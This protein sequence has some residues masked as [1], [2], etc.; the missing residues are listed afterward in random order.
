MREFISIVKKLEPTIRQ[1]PSDNS[2]TTNSVSTFPVADNSRTKQG[3][4]YKQ[5]DHFKGWRPR[6]FVLQ[7][8]LLHY[9]IDN[10]DPTP[11]NT[12]DLTGAS[13]NILKP[14]TVDGVEYFPFAITHPRSSPY[15]LS[16]TNKLESDLWVAKL[17]EASNFISEQ[18]SHH[19]SPTPSISIPVV[20]NSTASPLKREISSDVV[21]YEN[22]ANPIETRMYTPLTFLSKIEK[23]VELLIKK[24]SPD[25]GLNWEPLLEKN[26]VTAFKIPGPIMTVKSEINLPFS[27]IDVFAMLTNTDRQKEL[28]PQRQIQEKLKKFSSHTWV[29]YIRFKA[30]WPT[31]ARDFINL[32]HW[33]ILNDNRVVLF[34]F[35]TD[36]FNNLR[37]PGADGTVRGDML[38]GG[39]ILTPTPQGTKLQYLVETDLKGSLP[40]SVVNFAANTQPLM[41]V[42]LK[43]KLDQDKEKGLITRPANT[44]P[45][46]QEILSTLPSNF[47][48]STLEEEETPAEPPSTSST[49]TSSANTTSS[50]IPSASA[51]V[52]STSTAS[53]SKTDKNHPPVHRRATM[54]KMASRVPKITTSSL[55]ILYLPGVL[56]FLIPN[57]SPVSPILRILAFFLGAIICFF[58][59]IQ[60]HLGIP[61]KK[62]NNP[63]I[64][65][66]YPHGFHTINFPV[67]L[68]QLL[69]Y[70]NKKRTDNELEITY[71]HLI[72]KA[73]SLTLLEMGQINGHVIMNKFYSNKNKSTVPATS[74][75]SHPPVDTSISITTADSRTVCYKIVDADAKPIEMIAEEIISATKEVHSSSS[76]SK[77]PPAIQKLENKLP[78]FLL[79]IV[80]SLL[81]ILTAHFGI[82][83]LGLSAFPYGVLSVVTSPSL[84][85][86]NDFQITT[87]PQTSSFPSIFS[88]FFSTFP[89][90]IVNIGGIRIL[91]R[92]DSNR[93]VTGTPV[94]NLTLTFDSRGVTLPEARKFCARM[95]EFLTNPSLLEKMDQKYHFDREEAAKRKAYF[96]K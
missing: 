27:V 92:L 2:S 54:L 94:L 23:N 51:S 10:V 76:D 43:Q 61:D 18:E 59:L 14:V 37:A 70:L 72:T 47:P 84:D 1:K 90:I 29:D 13:I 22:T 58:Y 44:P 45:T 4:L 82:S 69:L 53:S 31:S 26:G 88:Y 75:A 64:G 87:L 77:V 24:L 30:V 34:A 36:K 19:T 40:S 80:K 86:E 38:L 74:V 62:K 91:P 39:F 73:A 48:L 42:T 9:F 93:V 11:R 5:R 66:S 55:F 57:T 65:R 15:N 35:S 78:T 16:T 25:S 60:L 21:M 12:L 46:Y 33:R 3:T 96:G 7:D 50:P 68:G 95:Q 85:S 41:L 32:S 52:S 49:T 81:D 20:S 71:T 8:N 17:I 56:Y 6:H 67:E 83:I 79:Y 28:D 89:S 63:I